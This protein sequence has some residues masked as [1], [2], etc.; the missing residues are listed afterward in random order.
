MCM[1]IFIAHLFIEVKYEKNL[2]M[3]RQAACKVN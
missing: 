3:Q 1:Q 2:K